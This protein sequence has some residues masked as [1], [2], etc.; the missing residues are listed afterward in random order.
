MSIFGFHL[1]RG[2]LHRLFAPRKPRHPLLRATF[3]LLG[4]AVLVVLVF[5]GLFIGA[6]MIGAGLAFRLWQSRTKPVASG[7]PALEAEYQVMRRRS[8]PTGR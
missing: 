8:L 5:F 3:A 7:R 4:L 1:E 2:R 6:A